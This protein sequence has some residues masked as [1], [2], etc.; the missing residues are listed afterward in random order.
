[1]WSVIFKSVFQATIQ[2]AKAFL[3]IQQESGSFDVYI[4]QFVGGTPKKN[5]W[6]TL[7]EVPSKTLYPINLES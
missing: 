4:W 5:A 3:A 2:N 6:K 1:M 7:K